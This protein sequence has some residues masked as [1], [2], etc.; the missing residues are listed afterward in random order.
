M[1][2]VYLLICFVIACSLNLTANDVRINGEAKL[3]ALDESTA[4]ITFPL[5]WEHS[6]REGENWDAVYIF[7]KYRRKGV[8]EPWHHAYLK[9]KGH[10]VAG[11]GAG[12]LMEFLPVFTKAWSFLRYETI[13]FGN[14]DPTPNYTEEVVPGVFLFR[15]KKGQGDLTFPRVSLEWNYKKGDLNLYYDVTLDDIR[16]GKIEV[17]V[18]AIEMVY[19]PNG[20]FYAGDR[21]SSY[22]LINKGATEGLRVESDDSL[23]IY[24]M[25]ESV[26]DLLDSWGVPKL[27]PTGYT[28]FYMMK[29]EVSQEQYVNFLNRLTYQDQKERISRN[30]D[31]LVPGEYAFGANNNKLSASYRNGIILQERF[32]TNDTPVIFGFDLNPGDPRNSDDDGKSIACNFLS[33]QDMYAYADWA[34]LRP[35][36]EMEYEKGCRI[37]NPQVPADRSFAW[38]TPQIYSEPSYP[39]DPLKWPGGITNVGQEGEKINAGYKY[40]VNGPRVSTGAGP[41]RCG[42]FATEVTGNE[43]EDMKHSGGSKWGLM[44][45]TGNL[46]EIYYNSKE[47]KF[48]NG[49]VFG[50]GNIWSSVAEWRGKKDVRVRG[51][52]CVSGSGGYYTAS[53]TVALPTRC[54][55]GQQMKMVVR[56]REWLSG[57]GY[58]C[59]NRTIDRIITVPYP[60][61]EWPLETEAYGL[62][63]GSFDTDDPLNM[64]VSSRKEASYFAT[65][66]QMRVK[67]VGFRGGRS[68]PMQEMKT[69]VITGQNNL[70]VD[71]AVICA[72]NP[73]TIKEFLVGDDEAETTVF[74]WEM[75]EG[76]EWVPIENSDT[77]SLTLNTEMNTTDTVKVIKFRRKSIA[78]H[79]EGYGNEVTLVVPGY[80]I[81]GGERL[82]I[83]MY[84]QDI[85]VNVKLGIPGNIDWAWS[86]DM[87]GPWTNFATLT[88]VRRDKDR[89]ISR[90][91][92]GVGSGAGTYAVKTDISM[93]GCNF[94]VIKGVDV[95]SYM[96]GDLSGT[97]ADANSPTVIY[98]WKQMK[99][100]RNWLMS[101]LKVPI[102]AGEA[103]IDGVK[104]TWPAS[105]TATDGS[106]LY[107]KE[108]LIA[109]SAGKLQLCPNGYGIPYE[110]FWVAMWQAYVAD[111]NDFYDNYLYVPS[112]N[113]FIADFFP[114]GT[115]S[116]RTDWWCAHAS[117]STYEK[118]ILYDDSVPTDTAMGPAQE[119]RASSNSAAWH[120]I[121]CAIRTGK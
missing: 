13:Y 33:P 63:G 78:S 82:R 45:M 80:T 41:V 113:T 66:D 50:D 54:K 102:P 26:T 87:T 108:H 29:Y 11:G 94:E 52:W 90:T 56:W 60:V 99:E 92:L 91:L 6:W 5:K 106:Q 119:R 116:G 20:P 15:A 25:G 89:S 101:N 49:E 107:C 8:N 38:G 55:T 72:A 85:E 19:V 71:T 83:S 68:V 43:S 24:M 57:C 7:V 18:Q 81:S 65:A 93:G 12:P 88:N 67:T 73:Y 96:Y 31:Q 114:G 95:I 30:L 16:K 27:Y 111:P 46:A 121:R 120:P 61:I 10:K 79:A 118:Y 51:T 34:G 48:F 70:Y 3:Q 112:L 69:G 2:R 117:G 9:E 109:E 40:N 32:Q 64:S 76:T 86:T 104:I 14:V 100:T 23:N 77:P 98:D 17:S 75:N 37:R 22:S 110:S 105:K 21:T 1:M 58:Y 103:T 47:G 84:A 115:M 97:I 35:H 4:I 53:T 59:C 62:R 28:G 36:S 39:Y 42:I 44:E 74:S